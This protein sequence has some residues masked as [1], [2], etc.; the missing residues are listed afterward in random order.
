MAQ[1]DRIK[2]YALL[3]QHR[4]LAGEEAC[5]AGETTGQKDEEDQSGG[6]I[7]SLVWIGHGFRNPREPDVPQAKALTDD[8]CRY[9]GSPL[10]GDPQKHCRICD[11]WQY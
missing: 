7:A 10:C 2:G 4:S 5:V 11:V 3:D 8:V 1:I 6:V 9:C